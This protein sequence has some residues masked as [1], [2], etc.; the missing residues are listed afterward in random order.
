MIKTRCLGCNRE[1]FWVKSPTGRPVSID[2]DPSDSGYVIVVDGVFHFARSGTKEARYFP[3]TC[4]LGPGH[5]D[6]EKKEAE[7]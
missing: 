5:P 7:R 6:R 4:I 2:A 1:V 3:H